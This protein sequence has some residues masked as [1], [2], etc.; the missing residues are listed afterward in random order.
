MYL[1]STMGPKALVG[2]TSSAELNLW[3]GQSLD[4]LRWGCKQC[5][6]LSK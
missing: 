4:G 5:D 3:C 2:C 6:K 1:Y